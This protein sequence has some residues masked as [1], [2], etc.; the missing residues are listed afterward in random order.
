MK[1]EISW[2]DGSVTEVEGGTISDAMNKAGIGAGALRA[3][4]WYAPIEGTETPQD[5]LRGWFEDIGPATSAE[6]LLGQM[7]VSLTGEDWIKLG[8]ACGLPESEIE[9]LVEGITNNDNCKLR[10]NNH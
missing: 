2:R 8:R 3:I 6:A 10:P 7:D 9:K 1:Y 5:I 4:D